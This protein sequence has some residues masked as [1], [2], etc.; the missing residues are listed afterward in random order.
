MCELLAIHS[1]GTEK[2]CDKW[3]IDVVIDVNSRLY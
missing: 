1:I 2:Q 3:F